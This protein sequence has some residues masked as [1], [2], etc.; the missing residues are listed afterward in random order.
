MMQYV[1][2]G[3]VQSFAFALIVIMFLLMIV[4]GSVRTGLIGLIPN[5]ATAI[6]V[7]GVMGWLGIPLDM[8]TATIIP[9]ILGL[10]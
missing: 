4:F 7:G 8:M 2:K 5:I 10:A 1:V 9:M 3:Q 6:A